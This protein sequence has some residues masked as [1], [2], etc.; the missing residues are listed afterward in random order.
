MALKNRDQLLAILIACGV[1]GE[2]RI[3]AK[4]FGA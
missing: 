1:V 2:S 3:L 4:L